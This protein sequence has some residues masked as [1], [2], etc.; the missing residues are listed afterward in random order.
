MLTEEVCVANKAIYPYDKE[1]FDDGCSA[2]SEEE[3]L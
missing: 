1:F 2:S 3:D